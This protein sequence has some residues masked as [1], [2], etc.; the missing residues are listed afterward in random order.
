MSG[1]VSVLGAFLA[2]VLSF[3]SPCV[4]PLVPAYLSFL[5]G[6]SMEELQHAAPGSGRNRVLPAALVFVAGFSL[7]FILLG[8]SASL[9]GHWLLAHFRL[10]GWIAG[11]LL[12]VL[13]LH[14]TGLLRLRFLMM[15][16]RWL[17]GNKP[18][19]GLGSFLVGMAFA[20]GWTPCVG[21]ML[22]GILA[23]A[24]SQGTVGKGMLLLACYSAGLGL[25]FLLAALALERFTRTWHRWAGALHWVEVISG[26][27]LIA[28]GL[29]MLT[30]TLGRV[31]AW[32]GAF[33]LFSL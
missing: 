10:L 14:L 28:L 25:P 6:L 19:G 21:P 22:A 29:A 15:E 27:F 8:A 17:P 16:K 26:V 4:L 31:S 24:G 20:F 11:A 13:G 5:T 7:V 12:V 3:L 18:L 9:L 33:K 32:V 23:L 2:G 30:N 1:S